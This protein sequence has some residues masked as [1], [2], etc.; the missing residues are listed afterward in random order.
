MVVFEF[1]WLNSMT[2]EKL[3]LLHK[4]KSVDYF[5]FLI[6]VINNEGN[7]TR[8]VKVAVTNV[9]EVSQPSD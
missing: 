3:I 4:N 6:N 9:S 1:S 5:F 7:N 8:L 2:S